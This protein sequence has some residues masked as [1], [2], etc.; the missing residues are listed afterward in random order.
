MHRGNGAAQSR[1]PVSGGPASR[2]MG[3]TD[4]QCHCCAPAAEDRSAREP[5]GTDSSAQGISSP[6]Q[7]RREVGRGHQEK[8]ELVWKAGGRDNRNVLQWWWDMWLGEQLREGRLP[9]ALALAGTGRWSHSPGDTCSL[10]PTSHRTGACTGWGPQTAGGTQL[11]Q[12][13]SAKQPVVSPAPALPL[14]ISLCSSPGRCAGHSQ[15]WPQQ[16]RAACPLLQ[17]AHQPR[18]RGE[19]GAASCS[20][21]PVCRSRLA[22]VGRSPAFC[23]KKPVLEPAVAAPVTPLPVE[24]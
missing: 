3:S 14:L 11:R 21:A 17:H 10:D 23:S 18:D 2:A 12:H 15:P 5:L 22:L 4:P 8:S 1:T 7:G 6:P 16:R 9:A 19:L 20:R 13:R 24:S